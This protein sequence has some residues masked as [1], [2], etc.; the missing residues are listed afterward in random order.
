MKTMILSLCLGLMASTA[1]AEAP[2]V[3]SASVEKAGMFWHITVTLEHPDT[4]W[5]HYADGWQVLDKNG[6]VLAERKLAHPH[7]DEQPFTRSLNNVM[8][9]DGTKEI[10]VRPKC[11]QDG[12]AGKG[13][14][15]KVGG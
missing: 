13:T 10:F 11:S 14:K 1:S 3:L 8:L 5:D 12:W 7:V 9:P 2:K 4:G 15:V 6:K